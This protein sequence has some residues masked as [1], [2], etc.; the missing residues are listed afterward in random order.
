M[1]VAWIIARKDLR[2]RL[3]DRS[4][5]VLGLVAPLGLALVFGFVLNPISDFTFSARYAVADLDQGPVSRSFAEGVLANVEG[6]EVV[7]VA[8]AAEAESLVDVT[9]GP[10][11]S[12]GDGDGADAAFIF[13]EGFSDDVQSERPVAIQVLGNQGSATNAGIA[14]ALAQGFASELTSVRVSVATVENVVG[15]EVDRLATG[16]EVL[17]TPSPA[18]LTDDT[19]ATKQL[20]SIT[21]YAAG[22][23]IFFLFFTVQSGVTALLEER[24][25]GTLSRLLSSPISSWSVL[26]GKM[27][28]AFL[29]GV[30]S[31]VVLVVA[32]TLAVG[33]EWGPPVGVAILVLAA[34]IAALGIVSL[35]GG[36]ARTAEQAAAAASLVGIILGFLGGTFFDVSQAGGIIANLRFVSPHGWFMQGLADLSAGDIAV[37][38]TPVLAMLAFGVVTGG[39]GMARLKRSLRA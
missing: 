18:V 4:A 2:Q 33:A 32:T 34:V 38:V 21:F 5:Y 17:Q 22:M 27:T 6:V 7:E 24:Q 26:V 39:L 23:S 8:T 36:F 19:A 20:D 3:R 10:L 12:S 16:V 37:I 35:V 31:M 9:V 15:S 14:V 1:R 11:G 30:V 25:T 13:P 28:S 29:V